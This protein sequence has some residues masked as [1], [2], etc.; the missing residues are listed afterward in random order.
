MVCV[1]KL[2]QAEKQRRSAEADAKADFG[3]NGE[4]FP[5]K[6]KCFSLHHQAYTYEICPYGKAHQREVRWR[7]RARG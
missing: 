4:F 6:G 7:H 5:L 2:K 1:G 3:P